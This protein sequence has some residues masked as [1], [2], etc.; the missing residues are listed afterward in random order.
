VPYF[1]YNGAAHERRGA[2]RGADRAEQTKP[3]GIGEPGT[4]PISPSIGTRSVSE[5]RAASVCSSPGFPSDHIGDM[6]VAMAT[7]M[8]GDKAV[9]QGTF[10]KT[11]T[12]SRD[13]VSR[14]NALAGSGRFSAFTQQALL[15]ELQRESIAAWLDERERSREGK[16]LSESAIAFA[17]DA[18]RRGR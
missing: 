6:I 9:E 5:A 3:T 14:V 13:V 10:R 8:D 1:H 12:L 17:E 15:H 7:K 11:V 4:P 18:W 16:P 2:H